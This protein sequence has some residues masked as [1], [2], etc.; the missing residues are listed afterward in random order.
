MKVYRTKGWKQKEGWRVLI[1]INTKIRLYCA[2]RPTIREAVD[3]FIEKYSHR[4][5]PT[6]T[7]RLRDAAAVF[8]GVSTGNLGTSGSG[9]QPNS[10]SEPVSLTDETMCRPS[11]ARIEANRR[12]TC[13]QYVHQIEGLCSDGKPMPKLS[14]IPQECG[15]KG[16][17]A[18]GQS[19][20]CGMPRCSTL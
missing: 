14:Q 11:L 9:S 2:L 4:I 1:T 6:E 5:S 10:A 17:Q 13:V 7:R 3:T 19:T 16:L 15:V 12:E 8:Q 20:F 18:W